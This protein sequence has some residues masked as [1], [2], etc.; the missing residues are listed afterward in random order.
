MIIS[1]EGKKDFYFPEKLED[2]EALKKKCASNNR[3]INCEYIISCMRMYEAIHILPEQI[4]DIYV[5]K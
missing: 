1:I 3:C 5:L 2:L 4:K